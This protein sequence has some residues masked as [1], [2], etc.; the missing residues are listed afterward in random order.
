MLTIY[1][2]GDTWYLGKVLD[3][4]AMI[5]GSQSGFVGAS[6][7]AALI[8]VLIISFQAI[9]RVQINIHQLLVCYIVYMGCFGTTTDVAIESVY[10]D[11]AVIQ[12]DNVPIGPALLGSVIST[13]GYKLTEKMEIAFS[14]AGEGNLI[15]DPS[16]SQKYANALYLINNL[17]RW[18]EKNGSDILPTGQNTSF[19]KNIRTYAMDCTTKALYLGKEFGGKD[20]KELKS[21]SFINALGFNSSVYGTELTIDGTAQSFK[22]SEGIQKIQQQFENIMEQLN[23]G[24]N[25]NARKEMLVHLGFCNSKEQCNISM[26]QDILSNLNS[27]IKQN[28][29]MNNYGI[30]DFMLA[31][32]GRN[33]MLTGLSLGYS[34]MFDKQ[35][36]TMLM[37][38]VM[39]RNVQWA[40]EQNMFLESV[41]PMLS[42]IEGFFYAVSPFTAIMI[43]L[44]LFGLKIF[45]KYITMLIWIQLWLPMMAVANLYIITSARQAI[46]NIGFQGAADATANQGMSLYV[47]ENLVQVCQTKIAVGGMMMAATPLLALILVSGS[48]FALTQLTNRISGADHINEKMVAPDVVGTAPIMQMSPGYTA[49]SYTDKESGAI[50]KQIAVGEILSNGKDFAS[51]QSL[52]STMSLASTL[53]GAFGEKGGV[54][55]SNALDHAAADLLKSSDAREFGRMTS[56][57]MRKAQANGVDLS[58]EEASRAVLDATLN[59]KAGNGVDL[60]D[61]NSSSNSNRNSEEYRQTVGDKFNSASKSQGNST[62]SSSSKGTRHGKNISVGGGVGGGVTTSSG[63]SSKQSSARQI[64]MDVVGN[65]SNTEK[66]AL[67]QE[68]TNSVR[69]SDSKKESYGITA[70]E[71]EAIS[72]ALQTSISDSKEYSQNYGD[73]HSIASSKTASSIDIAARLRENGYMGDLKKASDNIEKIMEEKHGK[74]A[75]NSLIRKQERINHN[76][77]SEDAHTAAI[78]E[79]MDEIKSTD[80]RINNEFAKL[81][82][83]AMGVETSNFE[84]TESKLQNTVP[85]VKGI[86]EDEF[87]AKWANINSRIDNYESAAK[88]PVKLDNKKIENFY[89]HRKHELKALSNKEYKEYRN[90]HY[91]ENMSIKG[92]VESIDGKPINMKGIKALVRDVTGLSGVDASKLDLSKEWDRQVLNDAI[93][94]NVHPMF[95]SVFAHSKIDERALKAAEDQL[96]TSISN[97]YA[98]VLRGEDQNNA[99][100]AQDSNAWTKTYDAFYDVAIRGGASD[101]GAKAYAE[102]VANIID[103]SLY[104][105]EKDIDNIDRNVLNLYKLR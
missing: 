46:Q 105:T 18:S 68:V 82:G 63:L 103:Q 28:L 22:C 98:T 1:S 6:E 15:T 44:G 61:S 72:K 56:Q 17:A 57:V 78:I 83:K 14:D 59:M 20:W 12:K 53:K 80:D 89:K 39:Q 101:G 43:M 65:S 70:S 2:V 33:E 16:G 93:R 86:T 40:A 60:S 67:T 51:K 54:D 87:K 34:S 94:N 81:L 9:L 10:S 47:Y 75:W 32:I 41:K 91:N 13:I 92:Q 58:K 71:E 4:I 45:F 3:A 55:Y 66:A 36:S 99:L 25:E 102:N 85:S 97:S 62:E 64:A 27:T 21:Q 42:F 30:N 35:S 77:S 74:E 38:A 23:S 88:T 84:D 76:G 73:K 79:A 19:A 37:N 96:V 8:G 26:A 100:F 48:Y 52:S 90:S 104:M 11:K 69:R 95:D 24:G 31:A 49:D 7:V 50:Y 29:R 5:S